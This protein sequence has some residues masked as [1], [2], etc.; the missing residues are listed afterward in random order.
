MM[1][2]MMTMTMMTITMMRMVSCDTQHFAWAS[3]DLKII[4]DLLL[5]FQKIQTER[6]ARRPQQSA[7]SP[8]QRAP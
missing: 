4:D 2:M 1:M 3:Q 8:G 6:I 5:L 7:R